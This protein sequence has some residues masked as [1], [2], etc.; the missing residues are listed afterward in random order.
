[1]NKLLDCGHEPTPQKGSACGTGYGIGSDG[2]TRCYACCA[3]KERADM[4]AT[5]RATLYLVKRLPIDPSKA[6]AF[7]YH[8][9]DWPGLLSFETLA[10]SGAYEGAKVSRNGGGFGS[11]RTDAWFVGPGGY[12]WHAVNR[13]DNQIARCHRTKEKLK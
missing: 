9:T 3:D 8:V 4:I 6:F 12:V 11:Q 7:R 1:M 2:K 13:G 10:R 5:G